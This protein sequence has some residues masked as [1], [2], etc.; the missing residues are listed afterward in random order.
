MGRRSPG[1]KRESVQ[2]IVAAGLHP[3]AIKAI[4]D[5]AHTHADWLTEGAKHLIPPG[6]IACRAGCAFCCHLRVVATIPEVLQIT[7]YLQKELQDGAMRS[8]KDRIARHRA[9]TAGRNPAARRRL[10]LACPLLVDGMCLAYQVRPLSCRGWNSIDVSGCES[11]FHDPSQDMNVP[12]YGAQYKVNAFIQ[13]GM[14]QGLDAVGLQHDPV[15]LAEAIDI[16]L[17]TDDPANRW[18]CGERIFDPAV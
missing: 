2:T 4:V 6:P 10:R 11:D 13:L 14:N 17:Q 1:P 3:G 18:L 8:L 15:E 7:G 5:D 12:V 9:C 16:A